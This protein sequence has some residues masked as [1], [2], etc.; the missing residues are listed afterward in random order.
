MSQMELHAAPAGSPGVIGNGPRTALSENSAAG[1]LRIR[2]FKVSRPRGGRGRTMGFEWTFASLCLVFWDFDAAEGAAGG[3][4]RCRTRI[5]LTAFCCD[6]VRATA[7]S[8]RL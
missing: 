1:A 4:L 2:T 7:F 3:D 8:S 5:L 6:S